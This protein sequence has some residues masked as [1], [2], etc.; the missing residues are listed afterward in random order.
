MALFNEIQVGRYN[1]ILHKLMGMKEG[2]PSPQLSGD[3]VPGI[4][5]EAD[6]PE[7]KFLAGEHLC[8]GGLALAGTAAEKGAVELWNPPGS[9]TLIVIEKIQM[10]CG[11]NPSEFWAG[12]QGVALAS[13]AGGAY[14][15]SRLNRG[16]QVT[17]GQTRFD[18]DGAV[19]LT[20]VIYRMHT[21]A[22]TPLVIDT[23]VIL[24]PGNGWAV[25][26]TTD[27]EP[28]DVAFSWQE[29]TLEPSELR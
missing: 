22:R 3:I 15:D 17:V 25:V 1:G 11:T 12:H 26:C 13:Q 21:L 23:P 24:T 20:T 28:I 9:G 2:A 16:S 4:I 14:L 19:L 7:W 29:R 18:T 6:R 10:T 27:N 5:L 8:M